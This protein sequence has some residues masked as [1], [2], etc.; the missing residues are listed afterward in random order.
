MTSTWLPSPLAASMAARSEHDL[1]ALRQTW[2]SSEAGELWAS[3]V[4]VTTKF[5]DQG[6]VGGR[7]GVTLKVPLVLGDTSPST[8]TSRCGR[9]GLGC[10]ARGMG[11]PV[12]MGSASRGVGDAAAAPPVAMPTTPAAP[13]RPT[14]RL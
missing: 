1:A 3:A 12:P 7:R 14:L 2:S 13:M 11:S 10:D 8:G 9:G 4:V 5:L 6:L